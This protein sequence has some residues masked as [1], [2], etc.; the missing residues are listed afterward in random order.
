VVEGSVRRDEDTIRIT[1][2]LID[3]E[4]DGH[5]WSQTYDRDLSAESI[6]DI[7]DDI[8]NAIVAALA[9]RLGD[10]LP[11]SAIEV[12]AST[13]NL[14]AFELYWRAWELYLDRRDFGEI[15]RLLA[16]VVELDPE[17]ARAWELRG[18]AHMLAGVQYGGIPGTS[19]E[20]LATAR[21]YNDIAL[22][23]DPASSLAIASNANLSVTVSANPDA[24]MLAQAIEDLTRAIEL[25]PHNVSAL[26]WRGGEYRQ[27]GY[28]QLAIDDFQAC[29]D[30]E[31]LS[32]ACQTS[33]GSTFGA[34]GEDQRA[35][36]QFIESLEL[37]AAYISAPIG[38]LA[39][40]GKRDLFILTVAQDY[41]DNPPWGTPDVLY[42]IMRNPDG[43]W[44]HLIP[45]FEAQWDDHIAYRYYGLIIGAYPSEF[46]FGWSP[47]LDPE[48][49][50]YR[51]SP[52]HQATL[53]ASPYPEF[54]HEYGFPPQC[55]ERDDGWIDC[56]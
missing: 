46:P 49:A 1:A 3:S 35:Y 14:D 39:R 29:I 24:A 13:D 26:N 53:Q 16:Q 23:L 21:E 34:M 55:H 9:E 17:Y 52:E 40:L 12:T 15:E 30:L 6:F 37:G 25:D 31:P 20:L 42:E 28:L 38:S 51:R 2:Q 41:P 4:N 5:L 32:S 8:A 44:D 47:L 33:L 11:Q 19:E 7:Q 48:N 56:D 45:A 18:A 50:A 36:D 22:A 43:D 10:I 54:W 27:V